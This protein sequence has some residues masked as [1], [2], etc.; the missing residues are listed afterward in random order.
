MA[1]PAAVKVWSPTELNYPQNLKTIVYAEHVTTIYDEVTGIEQHLGEGGVATSPSWG[2]GFSTATT[3]WGTL[4]DRLANI[5][6]GVYEGKFGS[7]STSG[8]STVTPTS[9]SIVNLTLKAYASQTASLL[10]FKDSSG[11]VLNS[12]SASGTLAKINGGTP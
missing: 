1:Y 5:E 12:V 10:E 2:G 4:K 7:V 8:N 9:T 6:K 3:S 11:T